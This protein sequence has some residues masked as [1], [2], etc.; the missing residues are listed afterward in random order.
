MGKQVLQLSEEDFDYLKFEPKKTPS[1]K[2]LSNYNS[3]PEEL[4]VDEKGNIFNPFTSKRNK[5]KRFLCFEALRRDVSLERLS[6]ELGLTERE[7][8]LLKKTYD[9]VKKC[10]FS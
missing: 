1:I 2:R 3:M 9:Q 8:D 5:A 7:T 4:I 6:K 10:Y